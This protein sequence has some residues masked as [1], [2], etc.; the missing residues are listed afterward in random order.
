MTSNIIVILFFLA[1]HNEPWNTISQT[2]LNE[3]SGVHT[4]THQ[5]LQMSEAATFG[6]SRSLLDFMSLFIEGREFERETF[7]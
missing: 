3:A 5:A 1:Q 6:K 2:D 4:E 7:F